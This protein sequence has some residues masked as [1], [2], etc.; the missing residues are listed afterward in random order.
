MSRPLIKA[1]DRFSE[2]TIDGE[3]VVM[4]LE[5]GSFFSL[6]QTAATAW[7]LI[8]GTRDLAQL[9]DALGAHYGTAPADIEADIRGFVA[10]L[11][12]AGLVAGD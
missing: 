6:T 3:V 5:S 9:V 12:G 11:V 10:E 7:Q 1:A 4:S 2:T 8:D